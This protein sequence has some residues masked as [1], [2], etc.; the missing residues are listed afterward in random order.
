M[1]RLLDAVYLLAL[2]LLSPWLWWRRTFTGRYRQGLRERLCGLQADVPA[3]AVWFHAVSLGEVHVLRTLVA[4]FR[5]RW[6]GRAVVVSSTT[7]T[8]LAEARKCF[9]ELTVFPFPFDFSW[10]VRATLKRVRP[11]M[12][13]LAE[14]ELWPNFVLAAKRARVPLAVVNAR[15]SPRSFGRYHLLGPVVRWLFAG[16]D[17]AGVQ[18]EEY[19][20]HF[21][22]LGT[23]PGR[24]R[25]TGNIKYDGARTDRRDEKTRALGERFGVAAGD[26]VW[27]A[28]STL[29]PEEEVVLDAYRRLRQAHANLRLFLAPR[30]PDRFEAVARLLEK[31]GLAF[32]RR[33]QAGATGGRGDVVLLDSTGELAALW[34]LAHLAFV[35]GSLDGRRGGQNM[36]EPAG[37]GAAV[38]FGPHV[39]NFKEPARRLVEVGGAY[40]VRDAAE[41]FAV[42][43]RLLGDA[44]ERRAA[45]AAA[46][47]FVLA[48]QGATGRTL[49]LLGE[50]L[51]AQQA[52]ERAA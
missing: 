8:G 9:A 35:G 45:G 5:Q 16:L 42:S 23:V 52:A 10:A 31:S 37:Y 28:G 32:V 48:Q 41:L 2:L 18:T 49:D 44:E 3:G 7:E 25:V 12:V 26:L 34:G 33:S 39:W 6:P 51:E 1:H 38:T 13:V 11:A 19:A 27:V 17:A 36:I 20:A 43:Q 22:Q 40:Q 21:L 24:V 29:A 47:A 30:Q 46:R 14:S 50:V 4:A 15:M